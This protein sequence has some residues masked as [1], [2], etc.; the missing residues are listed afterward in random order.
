MFVNTPA[1]SI[2]GNRY[3]LLNMLGEGSMGAVYRV[4]DR[5]QGNLVALKKVARDTGDLNFATASAFDSPKSLDLAL[6][7]EFQILAR[8]RHPHIVSVLDYGFDADKRPYFTMDLLPNARTI[9]EAALERSYADRIQLLL[10]LLE[11]LAYFHQRGII[12]R[13]LKPEN[14]LVDERGQL[15]V[16]DFGLALSAEYA[17]QAEEMLYGTLAYMAPEVLQG[18]PARAQSDLYGFGLIAYHVLGG[19]YPFD[20][21][22]ARQLIDNVLYDI[23]DVSRFASAIGRFLER[24]LAKDP[25][26]R[27]QNVDQVIDA[28]CEATDFPRPQESP[29]IRESYLQTAP[30]VGRV[31]EMRTLLDMIDNIQTH[32]GAVCLVGGE[33]GVGKSRFLNEIRVHAL[34]RNIPVLQGQAIAEGSTPYHVW[35]RIFQWLAIVTELTD[36][37]AQVLKD[38]LPS[39]AET[40]QDVP[41]APELSGQA[42]QERLINVIADILRRHTTPIIVLLEDLQ[43]AGAESLK[44]L[45]EL[46]RVVPES[47]VLIVG[48]YRHDE[49]PQLAQDI[50]GAMVLKLERFNRDEI[51]TLTHSILGSSEL[52]PEIV[53]FLERETAGNGFFLVETLR[54]LARETGE[55]RKVSATD[56]DTPV[57]AGGV[58]AVLQ[59]RL[60]RLSEESLNVLRLAAIIGR[61]LNVALLAHLFP[62]TNLQHWLVTCS[63]AAVLEARED[64]WYFAHDKLREHLLAHL[65]Q[66]EGVARQLHHQ[67]ATAIEAVYAE[68]DRYV[69]ALAHHWTQARNP[70]KATYYLEKA[71]LL[72]R[73]GAPATVVDYVKQAIEFDPNVENIHSMRQA[74]RHSLLGN[75][76][77]ALGEYKLAETHLEAA[78]RA[79]GATVTPSSNPRV[80]LGVFRQIGI[81]ILHRRAPSRYLGQRDSSEFDSSMYTG[82]F[83]KQVVYSYQG[84][85]LK[86]L[87]AALVAL[88][89]IEELQPSEVAT[90][91]MAYAALTL[92]TGLMG[93]HSVAGY[94]MKLTDTVLPQAGVHQQVLARALI[95][96]YSIQC[97][98][99][100]A[101]IET[102]ES[103]VQRF[104]QIGAFHS[105]DESVGYLSRAYAHTLSFDKALAL[106]LSSYQRA[107]QRNDKIIRFHLFVWVALLLI[108]KNQEIGDDFDDAHLLIQTAEAEEAFSEAFEA[109]AL[110]R[111]FYHAVRAL[112]QLAIGNEEQAFASLQESAPALS[113]RGVERSVLYFELY[114]ATADASFALMTPSAPATPRHTQAASIFESAVRKLA[115]Y[116]KVFTFARP[117]TYLYQ[118]WTQ[119][120]QRRPQQANKLWQQALLTADTLKMPYEAGLAHVTLGQS[121]GLSPVERQQHFDLAAQL[122]A[123]VEAGYALGKLHRD[124]TAGDA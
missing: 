45:R 121:E 32:K 119:I 55:L 115:R 43:W 52:R 68:H 44:L 114:A 23:P 79:L 15:R 53:D 10:Q 75:A 84:N 88:N 8:L 56:V 63:D 96:M 69:P 93:L 26:D 30:F 62:E 41:P 36:L 100:N 103:V 17:T 54:A 73:I 92:S 6:A 14:V 90:P 123:Q 107:R 27:Y 47:H 37:E 16:L 42:A 29:A 61:E 101:A 28:L 102:I 31:P 51:S 46:V 98:N 35:R 66:E 95:G 65:R 40:L 76:Y 89:T 19:S 91:V 33:S 5:L 74:R 72:A 85:M 20:V 12:H 81:Q 48:S 70:T 118:G 77:Y 113:G 120:L 97:A 3:L 9:H 106:A 124:N 122:F 94:Y 58:I 112:Y 64:R 104:N 99:W 50:P 59:Q 83:N 7:N 117:R 78:S 18:Q 67:V 60:S 110:N 87:H 39:S 2:I 86:I 22:N 4:V 25:E 49:S 105:A 57:A 108:R 13:D 21:S 24:L 82:L 11:A 109:N 111:S 71:A 38:F 80:A 34:V 1:S 116:G